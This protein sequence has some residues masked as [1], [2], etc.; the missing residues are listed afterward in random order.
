[1][2]IEI[3]HQLDHQ[4]DGP[5]IVRRGR[6]HELTIQCFVPAET[7]PEQIEQYIMHELGSGSLGPD[8]PLYNGGIEVE[9]VWHQRDTGMIGYTLWNAVGEGTKPGART[10]RYVLKRAGESLDF[11]YAPSKS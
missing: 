4:D 10:G 11:E 1:M 6:L 7:T 9:S 5:Q 8:N 3:R 2:S